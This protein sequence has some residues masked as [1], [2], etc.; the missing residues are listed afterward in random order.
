MGSFSMDNLEL[1]VRAANTL[2][3]L[4]IKTI[5]DLLNYNWRG[6]VSKK[7]V[8]IKTLTEIYQE[9]IRLSRGDIIREAKEYEEHYDKRS[10]LRGGCQC[11][12][13]TDEQ[14]TRLDNYRKIVSIVVTED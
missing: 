3:R 9:V 14:K 1:S 11:R 13:L 7:S 12:G 10:L 4:G 8:G 5:E 6:L 2:R